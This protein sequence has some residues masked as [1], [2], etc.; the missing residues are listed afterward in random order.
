MA[1]GSRSDE[2]GPRV[3]KRKKKNSTSK[4]LQTRKKAQAAALAHTQR[5]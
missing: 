2:A 4:R 3:Q 1:S 5:Q